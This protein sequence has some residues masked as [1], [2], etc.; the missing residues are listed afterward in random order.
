[1]EFTDANEAESRAKNHLLLVDDILNNDR[2]KLTTSERCEL[3]SVHALKA[4][5][6][7]TLANR[8]AM[9]ELYEEVADIA[10]QLR[11]R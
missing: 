4:Q 9:A 5:V 8:M 2:S 7:A 6:W 1:M 10:R 3:A 11:S